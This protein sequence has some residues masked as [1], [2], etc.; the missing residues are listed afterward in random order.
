MATK[1]PESTEAVEAFVLVDCT[2]GRAGEVVTLTPANAEL[3]AKNGVLDLHTDA[4]KAH[5]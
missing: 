2:F 5:K 4:I 1:K 3:G